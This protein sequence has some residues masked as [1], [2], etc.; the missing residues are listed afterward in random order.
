[1]R[2][3]SGIGA[4]VAFRVAIVTILGIAVAWGVSQFRFAGEMHH[5]RDGSSMIVIRASE[6][7]M[8]SEETHPDAPAKAPGGGPLTPDQILLVRAADEWGPAMRSQFTRYICPG[9]Q[10]TGMR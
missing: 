2:R 9:M 1:M 7:L 6:F 8:G 10:S 4:G 3:S 5:D